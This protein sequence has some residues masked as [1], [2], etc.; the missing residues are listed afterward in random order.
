MRVAWR[1]SYRAFGEKESGPL[2]SVA[3]IYPSDI[4]GIVRTRHHPD[5]TSTPASTRLA[6]MPGGVRN[7]PVLPSGSSDH[8]V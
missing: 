3:A 4:S 7:R 5:G 8:D 2:I 1:R 6:R